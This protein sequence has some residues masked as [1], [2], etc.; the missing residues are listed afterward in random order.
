MP[1]GLLHE[2]SGNNKKKK[3][4]KQQILCLSNT[5]HVC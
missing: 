1:A 2:Y 4:K 5:P 3:K